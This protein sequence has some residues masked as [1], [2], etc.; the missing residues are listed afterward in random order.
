L[1]LSSSTL[2]ASGGGPQT[3][4][5][6]DFASLPTQSITT[7]QTVT[8]AGSTGSATFTSNLNQPTQTTLSIVNGTGLV[9]TGSGFGT[10]QLYA[11][12][13]Q[14]GIT[15][16]FQTL[17]F[18]AQCTFSGSG[19]PQ[20]GFYFRWDT[21]GPIVGQNGFPSTVNLAGTGGVANTYI[22]SQSDLCVAEQSQSS[23][24]AARYL[25]RSGNDV[26]VGCLTASGMI[27][28]YFGTY[29]SAWTSTLRWLY[30][31]LKP[32]GYEAP[33]TQG[34]N[35]LGRPLSLVAAHGGGGTMTFRRLRVQAV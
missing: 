23:G 9:F 26:A 15:N 3:V 29:S 19:N 7:G 8:F 22:Q 12:F 32:T 10:M 13:A 4:Y 16:P 20:V 25:A 6:V 28:Q 5:E 24:G 30:S 17:I 1:T 11:T 18:W 33:F 14:L 21:E 34:S 31:A 27:S 35:P 2:I